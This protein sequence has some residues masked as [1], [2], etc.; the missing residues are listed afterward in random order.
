MQQQRRGEPVR[1]CYRAAFPGGGTYPAFD[2]VWGA[3]ITS[4][5]SSPAAAQSS[6][7]PLTIACSG[8]L[9]LRNGVKRRRQPLAALTVL[10]VSQFRQMTTLAAHLR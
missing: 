3:T 7:S 4:V 6:E 1:L 9:R 10:P 5:G 2:E 8:L